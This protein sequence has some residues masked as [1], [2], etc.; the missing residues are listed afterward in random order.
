MLLLMVVVSVVVVVVMVAVVPTT[1]IP[2]AVPPSV[3]VEEAG[4]AKLAAPAGRVRGVVL[5]IVVVIRIAL[6]LVALLGVVLVVAAVALW[7]HVGV[8]VLVAAVCRVGVKVRR[9]V[10]RRTGVVRGMSDGRQRWLR[11]LLLSRWLRSG[12]LL[13]RGL[14]VR[15]VVMCVVMGMVMVMVMAAHGGRVRHG[16][17]VRGWCLR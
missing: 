2:T 6:L 8:V 12:R 15:M 7:A 17:D 10:D 13:L 14:M 4:V 9:R 3:C 11:G 16:Y 5:G 1:V